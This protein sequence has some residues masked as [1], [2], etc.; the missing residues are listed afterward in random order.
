MSTVHGSWRG[1]NIVRDG[2]V[3]Y[4]DAGSPNSYPLINSSTTWRDI[5]GNANNGTLTNGPTYSPDNGGIIQF[6]GV[7]DYAILPSSISNTITTSFTMMCFLYIETTT[8]FGVILGYNNAGSLGQNFAL[9]VRSFSNVSPTAIT[10]TMYTNVVNVFGASTNVNFL[11][12]HHVAATY[13]GV[14]TKM[15][16]DGVLSSQT[17]TTGSFSPSPQNLYVGSDFI[18]ARYSKN[19]FGPT[20]IYNRALSQ[21]EIQ[22]NFNATR[23]RFGI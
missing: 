19:K 3:L 4:L 9:Q 13:D 11:E 16:L 5:S 12:W 10:L 15:Y 17:N 21:Q 18:R 8:T 1:P 6:D 23:A 7:N 14:N 20:Q 2:L 22:Q